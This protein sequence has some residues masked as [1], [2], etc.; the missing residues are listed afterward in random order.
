MKVYSIHNEEFKSYGKVIDCPFMKLFERGANEIAIPETGCSY[1][2]SVPAFETEEIIAYYRQF[3]G[4]MDVQIGYCWGKNDT[5]NALEWHKSS[6]VHCALEDML[7][8]LGDYRQIENGMFDTKN[9]KAFLV[10]KGESVEIY[11]TT[12][13]F[14]PSMPNGK[15]FRNVVILPRG[16]NTPLTHVSDDKKLVARNKWLIC[17]PDSKKHVDMGRIVGLVG[18]N[19]VVK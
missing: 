10:K 18:E 14:C 11:Q 12:L 19:V 1:M 7:L 3:F 4:D 5:L 2:A 16:T 9:I 15:V 8:L 17:H 13:H 6:E